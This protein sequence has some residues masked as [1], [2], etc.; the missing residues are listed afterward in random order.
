MRKCANFGYVRGKIIVPGEIGLIHGKFR[1]NMTGLGQA[2]FGLDT[3]EHGESWPSNDDLS[4]VRSKISFVL[5]TVILTH[6]PN[7]VDLDLF[8]A[9]FGRN[10]KKTR[11]REP[12]RCYH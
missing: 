6:C 2:N 9:D 10:N 7:M 3:A 8:E 1:Q 5:G 12:S 11:R 4:Y